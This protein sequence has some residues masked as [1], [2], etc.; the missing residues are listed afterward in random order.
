MIIIKKNTGS[1]TLFAGY[2]VIL[3]VL[4]LFALYST[5]ILAT[6]NP[7]A[8]GGMPAGPENVP[9]SDLSIE[10][11]TTKAKTDDIDACYELGYRFYKGNGIAQDYK[12]AFVWFNRAAELG[13]PAAQTTLGVMYFLG[14]GLDQDYN[15][16]LKWFNKAADQ[17]FAKA[18]YNLGLMYFHGTGVEKSLDKAAIWF[19]KAANNNDGQAQYILACLYLVA[20]GVNEDYLSAYKW[21][22]LAEY[23]DVDVDMIKDMVVQSLS[24]YEKQMA[25]KAASEFIDELKKNDST[26]NTGEGQD[27]AT[28]KI[29][30]EPVRGGTG[31][32]ISKDGYILTAYHIIRDSKDIKIRSALGIIP[33]EMVMYDSTC[34]FALLKIAGYINCK[35]LPLAEITNKVSLSDPVW[36][37]GYRHGKLVSESAEFVNGKITST[38]GLSTA[39]PLPQKY[40]ILGVAD[41]HESTRIDTANIRFFQ[42]ECPAGPGNA[43]AII[44]SEGNVVGIFASEFEADP[45]HIS[46]GKWPSQNHYAVK[47][48]FVLPFL[49][50]VPGLETKLDEI[51]KERKLE[52][53]AIQAKNATVQVLCY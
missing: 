14:Q 52:Q 2:P 16:S 47:I 18:Q 17:K 43:G 6:T 13:D 38:T 23:N 21:L 5:P 36:T 51:R 19:D 25:S 34:D 11:L 12:T 31:F 32:F 22:L 4:A 26:A 40:E 30:T 35:P 29:T 7:F 41:K 39:A 9:V 8:I 49:E 27:N 48:N 50:A 45:K 3:L 53:S 42:L 10:D 33:A 46:S 24:S 20:Q 15:L 37:F 44:G 28:A 1:T